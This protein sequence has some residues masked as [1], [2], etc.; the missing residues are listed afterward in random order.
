MKRLLSLAA[1]VASTL[2]IPHAAVA[3]VVIGATG[4]STDLGTRFGTHLSAL[5]D[6]AGMSAGY[7]S[8]VT[9]FETYVGSALHD[10]T[11]SANV[12][13]SGNAVFGVVT[14]DLGAAYKID[15]LALWNLQQ[16]ADA[17]LRGFTLFADDDAVFGNGTSANL[18][19]FA[20]PSMGNSPISSSEFGFA[21]V[22]TRYLQLQMTANNGS[23]VTTGFGEIVF[24]GVDVTAVPE[25]G[26]MALVA[27]AVLAAAGAARRRRKTA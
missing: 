20:P 6:Q 13:A 2:L 9:N 15:G 21:E 17:T 3:G 23:A 14:F 19:A 18:G 25:P 16:G 1:M 10:S 27:G 22:T 7:T 11:L 8:G 5:I 12:W 26:S 24:R 4:V